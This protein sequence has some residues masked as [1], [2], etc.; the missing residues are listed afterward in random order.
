MVIWEQENLRLS[1]LLP[2]VLRIEKGAFTDLPTQTV[3]FREFGKVAHRVS[4]QGKVL[5]VSTSAATFSVSL[6][7]G[8][9]LSVT[10][11]EIDAPWYP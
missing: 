3:W 9:L 5:T 1:L 8:K 6:S 2:E 10:L 4:E 11:A 7:S